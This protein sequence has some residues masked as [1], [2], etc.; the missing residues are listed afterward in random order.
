MNVCVFTGILNETPELV[1]E[2]GVSFLDLCVV[3]PTYRTTKSTNER[4]Q[5]S[6]YIYCEAWSSGAEAIAK[7]FNKGDTITIH[8]TAKNISQDDDRIIFRISEFE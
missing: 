1:K 6:T 5:I 7:T 4:T 2:N 3:V 8:C